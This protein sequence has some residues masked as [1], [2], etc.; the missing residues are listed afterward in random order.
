MDD[1]KDWL[2][3]AARWVHVFSAM[4]WIGAT[5]YFTWL[6]RRFHDAQQNPGGQVWM[7]HSGGFYVVEKRNAPELA[8]R[9]LHWF[10]WEAALTWLSGMALFAL[11]YYAGGLLTD[12]E[13]TLSASKAISLSLGLIAAGWVVYDL[14]WMSPLGRSPIAGATL[15]YALLV[16][17]AWWLPRVLS[18]RAA[19]LQ[20]GAMMGT[21]MA[22]NVWMRILPAQ[23]R[24]I[25]AV[26]A[27]GQPDAAQAEQAKNRSKH[28]TFIVVP[29]ILVMISNHFPTLTYGG[30]YGWLRLAVLVLVGAAGAK[31]VREH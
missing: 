21:I 20:L 6:D 4:L 27:G 30:S 23:R 12:Y 11:V 17:L 31:V 19:W 26:T 2:S 16:G 1:V 15:C 24:M 7:V 3:L 28:N 8:S 29:V 25:A 10:R 14:L 18:A 5:W 9:K 22:A 13:S